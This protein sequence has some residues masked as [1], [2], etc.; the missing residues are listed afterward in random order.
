MSLT[1]YDREC[2][3][4]PPP[5]PKWPVCQLVSSEVVCLPTFHPKWT[6]CQL[7]SPKVAWLSISFAKSRLIVNF[8]QK[9]A[10]LSTCPDYLIALFARAGLSPP[11]EARTGGISYAV[12]KRNDSNNDFVPVRGGSVHMT[13]GIPTVIC[14][15]MQSGT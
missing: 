12:L 3:I 8:S 9:V 14:T 5:R 4:P 13:V 1:F 10:C 11:L 7:V 15:L 2:P 6:A